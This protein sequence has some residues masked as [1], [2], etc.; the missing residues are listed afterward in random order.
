MIG[1]RYYGRHIGDV[2]PCLDLSPVICRSRT[3]V[4]IVPCFVSLRS[5]LGLSTLPT[6][7]PL[8]FAALFL[9]ASSFASPLDSVKRAGS[10]I[11]AITAAQWAQLNQTVGGKL[12]QG[13]P[14]ARPCFALS[15]TTGNFD[16]GQCTAVQAGSFASAARAC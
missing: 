8:T 11:S 10:A 9:A 5:T 2:Q 3:G 1:R 12:H 13:T 4:E 6:M 16:L 15:S 7:I 14:W